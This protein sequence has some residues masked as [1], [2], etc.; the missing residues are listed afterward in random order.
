MFC[1]DVFT[2]VDTVCRMGSRVG[3]LLRRLLKLLIDVSSDAELSDSVR[4][5]LTDE[6]T[7]CI[8]LLDAAAHGEVQVREGRRLCLMVVVE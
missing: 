5:K 1:C 6:T 3:V 7:L 8:K 4:Q 2:V